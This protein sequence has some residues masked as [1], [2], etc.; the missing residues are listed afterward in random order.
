MWGVEPRS[1][2]PVLIPLQGSSLNLIYIC[3]A[4]HTDTL[5]TQRLTSGGHWLFHTDRNPLTPLAYDSRFAK[6]VT[7]ERTL[8]SRMPKHC[9]CGKAGAACR[10]IRFGAVS[11]VGSVHDKPGLLV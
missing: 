4:N 3:D 6:N 11:P 9:C 5:P 2:R 10:F 7:K 1:H 8:R